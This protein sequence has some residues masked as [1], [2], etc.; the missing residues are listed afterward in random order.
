MGGHDTPEAIHAETRRYIV[1]F[2]AL[3][4]LTVLTVAVSYLHLYLDMAMGVAVLLAMVIA[5]VKA[6]LVAGYFMHLLNERKT[7][8]AILAL[9]IFFF[10][11][12]MILPAGAFADHNGTS[13]EVAHEG[14]GEHN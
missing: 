6:A 12:V 11:L 9:T 5:S 7:I 13:T 10:S 3:A 8:Y 14:A 2:A 1:V 4:A